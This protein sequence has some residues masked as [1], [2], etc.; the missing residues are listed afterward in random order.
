MS[1]LIEWISA[2]EESQTEG[3]SH[4]NTES[5]TNEQSIQGNSAQVKSIKCDDCGKVLKDSD[6]AQFHSY[7]SSHSN[8]SESTE[9][10][11]PMTE[12]E[13]KEQL[14]RLKKNLARKREMERE[15]DLKVQK[16]NEAIRRKAGKEQMEMKE[17]MEEKKMQLAIEERRREK[18]AE[19]LAKERVRARIEADKRERQ[20]KVTSKTDKTERNEKTE[21]TEETAKTEKS[22]TV[23]YDLAR[24]QIRVAGKVFR[25]EFPATETLLTVKSAVEKEFG[26][27]V[28]SFEGTYPRRKY[29]EMEKS[30]KELGLVPSASL[31]ASVK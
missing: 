9:E 27:L 21:K 25:K 13:K 6:A 17:K 23:N 15:D 5:Q 7:K 28:E 1:D 3:Q 31:I 8:F 4:Q 14:E 10:Y 20:A 11:T 26:V 18:E 24:I 29:S 22:A 16:Q 12:E 19:R 2:E 30:L